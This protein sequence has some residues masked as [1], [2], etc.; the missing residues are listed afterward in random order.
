MH[1]DESSPTIS[2]KRL[3]KRMGAGAALAW[4]APVLAS[5][6]T[7]AFAQVYPPPPPP[8]CAN[9]DFV[10]GGPDP[11]VCGVGNDGLDCF[12]EK[13]SAGQTI[14]ANDVFCDDAVACTSDADCG[15]GICAADTCCGQVCLSPCD[16]PQTNSVHRTGV[17]RSGSTASGR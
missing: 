7:P 16:N 3:L 4:S 12:C 17:R 15:G 1:S 5:L 14:C 11:V 6:K 10:C 9:Q 13:G 2:R 8:G